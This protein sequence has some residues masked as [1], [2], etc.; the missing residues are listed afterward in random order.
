MDKLAEMEILTDVIVRTE[1]DID[2]YK[3]KIGSITRE[4]I[5]EGISL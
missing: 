4:A 1:K 5:S 2:Y 3:E